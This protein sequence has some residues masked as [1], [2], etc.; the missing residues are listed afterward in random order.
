MQERDG[1]RSRLTD[2]QFQVRR[3]ENTLN[4]DK[5]AQKQTQM[6]KDE[7]EWQRDANTKSKK[8]IDNME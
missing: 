4:N 8:E 1:L 7:I 6:V 3:L 5:M 2:A